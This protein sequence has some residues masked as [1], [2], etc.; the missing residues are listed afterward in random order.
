[1]DKLERI[2]I[3]KENVDDEGKILFVEFWMG[4]MKGS[5]DETHDNANF[6]RNRVVRKKVQES[7]REGRFA[8]PIEL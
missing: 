2:G 1:V 8:I 6:M 7:I 3:F 5:I 4:K